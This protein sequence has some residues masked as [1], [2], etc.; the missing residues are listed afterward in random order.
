MRV[1]GLD[2]SKDAV[3][4]VEIESAFGRFEIRETYEAPLAPSDSDP[5]TTAVQ[6]LES[7]PGKPGRLITSV[8][9]EIGTFRNIQLGTRDK[10][11][12]RAALNFELEDDLPFEAEN[13]HYDYAALTSS[14]PGTLVHVG[15]VKKDSFEAHLQSL[16]MNR[17]D[18]DVVTTD[19]WAFRSL[20]TRFLRPLQQGG[21]TDTVLLIGLERH[22]TFFYVNGRNRPV[23]YREIPFGL[24]N[25]E[26]KLESQ[27][28][29]SEEELRSWVQDIGV[30]GINQEVSD[31]IAE[32]LEALVPEIKQTELAAR[33]QIKASI[34]QIY[35]TGEGALMPGIMNW[36]E[37]ASQLPCTLFR[38]LSALSASQIAY[39][40]LSEVRFAKALALATTQIPADRTPALNLRKGA[41]SKANASS[42]SPLELLKKPLPYLL[43]TALVFFATK[44]IETNYYQSRLSDVDT[45]V[46]R[47]VKTYYGDIS[48]SAARSYLSNPEKLKKT[49]TGDLAK[50]R[51]L[52]KLFAPNAASPLN[53]L[54]GLS[55]KIGRDVVVDLVSFD[56]GSDNVDPFVENKPFKVSLSFVIANPQIMSKLSDLV[57]KNFSLKRGNSEELTREGRKVFRIMYSGTIGGGK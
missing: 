2:I 19:A 52:S 26:H 6:L 13:L 56:A 49:I 53:L 54:K 55:E 31:A 10:K 37:S 44:I 39:S 17:I 27:L 38:P 42:D 5:I 3:A 46:K 51:E 45:Q 20:F 50:E 35:L 1:L 41:F 32:I 8:P 16:L 15:A 36:F 40:E 11:A 48:D 25:I 24:V 14:E 4:C 57:E 23:L 47:A 34:D 21:E 33:S 30:T 29:A 12:I 7:I 18:P 28:S 43:M 9:V 22:K